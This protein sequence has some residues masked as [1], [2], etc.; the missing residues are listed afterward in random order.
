MIGEN[1]QLIQQLTNATSQTT[2]V[3]NQELT[4]NCAH[5]LV[6]LILTIFGSVPAM[7]LKH[8]VTNIPTKNQCRLLMT[9][10]SLAI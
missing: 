3:L 8:S 1:F 5:L 6:T 7:D 9:N 4:T 2:V 10:Q